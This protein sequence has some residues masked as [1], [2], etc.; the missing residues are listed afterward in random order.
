MFSGS[1][2]E[3]ADPVLL[4]P[5]VKDL[6]LWVIQCDRVSESKQ[7]QKQAV[8]FRSHMRFPHKRGWARP[9]L[10]YQAA[11][12]WLPSAP[13]WKCPLA[14]TCTLKSDQF[15]QLHLLGE[16][17]GPITYLHLKDYCREKV[18]NI[19]PVYYAGT[20][21]LLLSHCKMRQAF[22]W[23]GPCQLLASCLPSGVCSTFTHLMSVLLKDDISKR[24]SLLQK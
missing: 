13:R 22:P 1:G 7:T 2:L 23:P 4:R 15:G 5:T 18:E 24:M 8:K 19:Y 3:K 14:S 21:D 20:N 11:A 16:C 6:T 12:L 10:L 9:L 17:G